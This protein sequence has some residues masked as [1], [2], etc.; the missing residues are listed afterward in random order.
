[1]YI[2][3][4]VKYLLF[5]SDVNET[6]IFSTDFSK[7]P[8]IWKFMKNH[9]MGRNF[10]RMDGWTEDRRIER[11]TE[12]RIERHDEANSRFLNFAKA[13]KTKFS[14]ALMTVMQG[15]NIL[16]NDALSY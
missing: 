2:G 7:N 13:P 3:I 14:V 5:L 15:V 1:M 10:F 16:F 8:Q 4:H 9:P 11:R 12:R 6:L